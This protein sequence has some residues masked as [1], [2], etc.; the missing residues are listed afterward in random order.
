MKYKIGDRVYFK[1]KKY[2]V[3]TSFNLNGEQLL[4]LKNGELFIKGFVSALNVK[5]IITCK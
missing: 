5:P 2:D 4:C 1:G 3:L